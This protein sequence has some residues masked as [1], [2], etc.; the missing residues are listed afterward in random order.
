MILLAVSILFGVGFGEGGQVAKLS[1]C[2]P[3]N[4]PL[5]EDSILRAYSGVDRKRESWGLDLSAKLGREACCETYG[6]VR[7]GEQSRAN[8][9]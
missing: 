1:G 4:T 5:F 2:T 6:K 3:Y 7:N 8:V 9:C